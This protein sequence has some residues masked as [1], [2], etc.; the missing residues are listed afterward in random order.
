MNPLSGLAADTRTMGL[1][2]GKQGC[3]ARH[4]CRTA[5][6]GLGLLKRSCGVPSPDH[7]AL[8][9]SSAGLQHVLTT[10]EPGP[11]QPMIAGRTLCLVSAQRPG[12]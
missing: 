4:E 12:S 11:E 5:D 7:A 9:S 6:P 1:Q 8:C 3:L 10:R 2:F